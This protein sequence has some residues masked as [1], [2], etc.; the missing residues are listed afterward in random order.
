M[1]RLTSLHYLPNLLYHEFSG[2]YRLGTK[3][4]AEKNGD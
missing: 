3:L 2:S 4:D 1:I